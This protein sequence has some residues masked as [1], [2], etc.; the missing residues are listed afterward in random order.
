MRPHL[1]L[2]RSLAAQAV[3]LTLTVTLSA[4][5][6]VGWIAS[7]RMASRLAAQLEQRGT[8]MSELLERHKD[9]HSAVLQRDPQSATQILQLI[10]SSDVEV[11]YVGLLDPRGRLLAAAVRDAPAPLD[12][13]QAQ[14]EHH[15]L[16]TPGLADSDHLIRRFTQAVAADESEKGIWAGQDEQLYAPGTTIGYLVLGM[17]DRGTALARG[18]AAVTV[19]GVAIALSAAFLVLFLALA[20][21]LRRILGFAERLAERD[22]TADLPDRSEDEVG[23]VAAALRAFRE[24]TREVV[25]ELAA[26]AGALEESSAAMHA[27]AQVQRVRAGDQASRITE[28][29]S[30]VLEL[31]RSARA[32][33]D[34]AESVIQGSDRHGRQAEEG[35]RAVAENTGAV[36]ALRADVLGTA[37]RLRQLAGHSARIDEIARTVADLA[38]RTHVL[39]INTGIEAARSG[40]EGRAF[41]I[42]ADEM[43]ELA[44]G[45][46]TATGR[47][48]AMLSEIAKAALASHA[49]AAAGNDQAEAAAA[50]ARAAAHAI[51]GLAVALTGSVQTATRIAATTRDQAVTIEAIATRM[52]EVRRTAEE[53]ASDIAGLESASHDVLGRAQRLQRT[54][55]GYHQLGPAA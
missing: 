26:A 52:A 1:L 25:D 35:R 20:R 50:R 34:H 15:P 27:S 23:R 36:E 33:R 12:A 14:L 40:D 29:G 17:R 49:A 30:S 47:V 48:R 51:D 3:L 13:V 21:R 37:E 43:R 22:L 38:D 28:I 54:V 53:V 42:V 32:A 39:A 45:S 44:A 55:G 2:R 6:L 9:L 31:E 5:V 8:S 4:S 11:E 19:T 7:R 24:R 10:V 16:D 41:R 46:R 18:Y